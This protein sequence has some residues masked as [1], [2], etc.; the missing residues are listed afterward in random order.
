MADFYDVLGVPAG[1]SAREITDAHRRLARQF[2][3]DAHPGV[4][5]A[6][7]RQL[8]QAMARINEAYNAIKDDAARSRY[9]AQRRTEQ[10]LSQHRPPHPWEC[11]LC[12][13]TPAAPVSYRHQHAYLLAATLYESGGTLCRNCAQAMGRAKQNRTLWAGWWGVWAFFRNL[14]TV[15]ANT[16]QLQA[17]SRMEPPRPGAPEVVAPLPFPLPTGRPVFGRFGFWMAAF[18]CLF[19]IGAFAGTDQSQT[20][21]STTRPPVPATSNTTTNRQPLAGPDWAVGS[22]VRFAPN[23]MI[24][25]VFC[26]ERYDG[27][28]AARVRFESSCPWNTD[29]VVSF[30]G[31]VYC[32]VER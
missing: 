20:P 27:R 3:P 13:S 5:A 18:A 23:S 9:D 17:V 10:R 28:V 16:R 8:E 31:W 25:P 1:A 7:R 22:C 12:G 4:T 26:S 19:L 6:E 29:W 2:H 24:A 30:S 11:M 15:F 21:R 14:S 32:I